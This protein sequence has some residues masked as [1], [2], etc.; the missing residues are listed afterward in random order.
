MVNALQMDS[1]ARIIGELGHSRLVLSRTL[2]DSSVEG[3]HSRPACQPAAPLC[4][5]PCA[6]LPGAEQT[7][8]VGASSLFRIL[9]GPAVEAVLKPLRE[10]VRAVVLPFRDTRVAAELADTVHTPA[11]GA[12][13]GSF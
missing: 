5:E 10:P 4:I 9:P 13:S 7:Q 2:H 12:F 11:A 8:G 3:E 6:V 1:V